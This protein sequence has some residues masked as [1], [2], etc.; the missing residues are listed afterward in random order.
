MTFMS[1]PNQTT[2]PRKRGRGLRIAG[3]TLGVLVLLLV[4]AYFVGTS[5]GFLKSVILPRVS[6]AAGADVTVSDA[7]IRP[8]K[9]LVLKDLKIQ[10]KGKEPLVTAPEV[11]VQYSVWQILKGNF[12]IGLVSVKSPTVTFVQA[13][14]DTT[15]IDPL[16][17]ALPEEPTTAEPATVGE[18]LKVRLDQLV[19]EK[20]TLR[21][22]KQ[23]KEGNKDHVEVTGL[24]I[25]L[26]DVR[27]DFT[28][29]LGFAGL[30]AAQLSPPAGPTGGMQASLNGTY[31]FSLTQELA[32]ASIQG[33]SRL[34][35]QQS[36]GS[37]ADF[38]DMT[39]TAQVEIT[40]MEIKQA[41]LR[42]L[43]GETLLS[44]VKVH[45]PFDLAKIEGQLSVELT[46]VDKN[47][48]NLAGTPMGLGFGSTTMS[49]T[50]LLVLTRS[51]MAMEFSGQFDVKQFQVVQTNLATPPMN[52]AA[53]YDLSADFNAANAV[54]KSLALEGTRQNRPFLVGKLSNPM[55]FSWGSQTNALP[56][57]TLTF[58]L[59]DF[60][61]ADWKAFMGESATSGNISGTAT[62]KSKEGGA[63]IDLELQGR[64]AQ[65]VA[66][67][68]TNALKP[69]DVSANAKVQARDFDK[70]NI[71][72][73]LFKVNRQS[74]DL[75]TVTGFGTAEMASET[76]NVQASGSMDLPG[77]LELMPFA[78]MRL[79]S[80]T[81]NFNVVFTQVK[82]NQAVD[83]SMSLREFT[84]A[85]SDYRFQDYGI[86]ADFRLGVTPELVRITSVVGK[87]TSGSAAGGAF[88][89]N[90]TYNLQKGDTD[91]AFKFHDFNQHSLKPFLQ[92]FLTGQDLMSVTV[93]GSASTLYL[94]KG[95]SSVKAA[96]SMTNLVVKTQGASQ[97]G[98]PLEADMTLDF[99]IS[100]NLAEI[101]QAQLLLTPTDRAKNQ[102]NMTGQIDLNDTDALQGALR[103]TANALD[104]TRYY[105]LF[106]GETTETTATET[107]PTPEV[108]PEAMTFPVKQFSVDAAIGAIYLHE[109]EIT[110]LTARMVLDGGKIQ[111]R[112]VEFA[113]NGAAVTNWTDLD[114]G[115]VGWKYDVRLGA[116]A[117][118]LAPLVNSL[119]PEYKGK[120][121]GT[122]TA[123]GNVKGAGITGPSLQ[124]SLSGQCDFG[125]T[126]LN[127]SV[128]NLKNP[129]LQ[130]IIKVIAV[131]PELRSN[132]SAGL[133]SLAGALFGSSRTTKPG[134][135]DDLSKSPID[136]IEA[137]GTMGDGKVTLDKSAIQSAKF[138]ATAQGVIELTP[139]LTN[140]LINLPLGIAVER[141]LAERI[142]FLPTGTPTNVVYV[143]LP[144]YV[145]V[146]GTVGEPK[147]DINKVAILGT[148]LEQ[149]GGR[150]P[151]VDEKTGNL[152]Q[153]LGSMLT[154]SRSATS[155]TNIP[156]RTST[157][158]PTSPQ[159]S[160]GRLLQGLGG[161]L[162]GSGTAGTNLPTATSTT[163]N[164]P[165]PTNAAPTPGSLL[166]RL[167]KSK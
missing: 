144:N 153:G 89:V 160:S 44:Q 57:S 139:V 151:G 29:K 24:D 54:L 123:T 94:P 76:A 99:G 10:A 97:V 154:G 126:N 92:P 11:R 32:P 5:A 55:A 128:A 134:W 112:P 17:K 12:Q 6:E 61:L 116:K 15:N 66:L 75:V 108:E 133:G 95:T 140:S 109:I 48:L 34:T 50:N 70:F 101:R 8:F 163:T 125:T 13:A 167:L 77:L 85:Y 60:E 161:L 124:K 96:M 51:G 42:L 156:P 26:T 30:L 79:T 80:G 64:I 82:T 63:L 69:M 120:V 111:L 27:N 41:T 83:G 118:P 135:A 152:I 81:A 28:G 36:T 20:A 165:T 122:F 127:L 113:L 62:V 150:I 59:T 73:F 130:M 148:A 72:E 117:V 105:D 147:A 21:Y 3:L 131:V 40:P 158:A 106:M 33:E 114:L 37:L 149:L 38:S 19:V 129:L 102:V 84:G 100:Q 93:Y 88:Q 67:G 90:G 162:G 119:M 115:V 86:Q 4:A 132:P 58:S 91:L 39:A 56:D 157:N 74:S 25:K 104:V 65:L 16:L 52:F 2:A 49:S 47:V 155:Q 9:E 141:S 46:G 138:R 98:F 146:K 7:T 31:S 68:G 142:N 143:N 1:A 18:P 107:A 136:V 14:D 110:N 87:V 43:K 23:H 53:R 103:L 35:V 78:D 121:A 137:S 159:S 166:N 164:T 145:T 71:S 45:G 22:I